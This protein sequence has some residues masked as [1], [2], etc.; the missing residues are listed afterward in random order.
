VRN[1]KLDAIP[2]DLVDSI[3]VNKTLS[4]NQEGDAIGGSVNL[5]T[6]KA[7]DQPY[8]TVLA[9]GGHTPIEGGGT[10]ISSLGPLASAS[11]ERSASV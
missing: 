8:V 9:M 1:V 4:A 2:A 5:V 11:A 10:S 7:T 6:K 3:E